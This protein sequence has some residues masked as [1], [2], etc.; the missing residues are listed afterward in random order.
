MTHSVLRPLRLLSP[1]P[2]LREQTEYNSR[3]LAKLNVPIEEVLAY[4]RPRFD[5]GEV[6]TIELIVTHSYFEVRKAEV[7]LFE[8]LFR[9]ELAAH[10]L[11]ECLQRFERALRIYSRADQAT[12]RYPDRHLRVAKKGSPPRPRMRRETGETIWDIP[13]GRE[14]RIELRFAKNYPWLP[15]E[16]DVLQIAAERCLAAA[17]KARVA[18]QLRA[19]EAEVRRL[20][21][22]MLEIEEK[23][24]RRISRE[25]HDE[26]GQSL[27]CI[28]LGL[29]MLEAHTAPEGLGR[30]RETRAIAEK[31]V[32]EIRRLL[33]AL[34]PE[35]LEKMGL[36]AAVRQ[37]IGRFRDVSQA[38][39]V[40]DIGPLPELPE[41]TSLVLYRLAQECLHNASKHAHAKTL[42]VFL[43]YADGVVRFRLEDD[44]V[45]FD[46]GEATVKAGSTGLNGMKQRVAL[47]GGQITIESAMA[48]DRKGARR[49]TQI[50]IAIPAQGVAA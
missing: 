39:V 46:V 17:D 22:E 4:L 12:V 11:D 36:A 48:A 45:G 34:N 8:N 35:V 47:L 16:L 28:R 31:T 23:E 21:A 7:E 50:E 49:G 43:H 40:S 5:A 41:R 24:R 29:E 2:A 3:R 30:L 14:G 20:A 25:L 44:G 19:S 42:K 33:S 9:S 13:L 38:R 32:V 27:L 1:D 18:D 10:S 6:A 26:A 15:R 37:L